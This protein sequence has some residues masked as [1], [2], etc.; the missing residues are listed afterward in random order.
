MRP[1][2]KSGPDKDALVIVLET[3][4]PATAAVAK[5]LLENEGI[6]FHPQGEELQSAFVTP[7]AGPVRFQVRKSDEKR[8]RELLKD[9]R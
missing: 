1:T 3:I 8:A 5:S 9:L 2:K 7:I 6:P 4:N